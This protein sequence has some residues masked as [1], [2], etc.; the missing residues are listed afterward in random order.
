MDSHLHSNNQGHFAQADG[1]PF[2]RPP[3]STDLAFDGCTVTSESILAGEVPDSYEK[4][5]KA[6]LSEL[7]RCREPILPIID[8]E[9]MCYSFRKWKEK[10]TTS[11]SRKHLGIY[12]SLLNALQYQ[13]VPDIQGDP[14]L[15]TTPAIALMSL[16][17][18]HKLLNLAIR[19]CHSFGR[20]D[21]FLKKLPGQPLIE[22]LRVIHIYEADWNFLNRYFAAYK[23]TKIAAREK[24]VSVEQGG[25]RPGRSSSEVAVNTVLT[26]EIIRMQRLNGA[27]IYNDAKA[28]YDRIVEN[29]ANLCLLRE[30]YPTAV[31]R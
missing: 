18:Q 30:G 25:G 24:S 13:I 16:Q 11:P 31:A 6:L 14:S 28:C 15:A 17:I 22:K 10:T 9:D 21:F 8:F 19:E 1:T 7:Q 3:L 12:K 20:C 27:I 26:Y 29:F 23:L 5:S 2:T 4:F